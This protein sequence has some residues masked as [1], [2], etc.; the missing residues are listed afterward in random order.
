MLPIRWIRN[1]VSDCERRCRMMNGEEA[2][3]KC[4]MLCKSYK[5]YLKVV[6]K[7]SKKK[8]SRP[9]KHKTS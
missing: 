4:K 8:L 7:D 2:N 6:V 3:E 1:H 9:H 5:S